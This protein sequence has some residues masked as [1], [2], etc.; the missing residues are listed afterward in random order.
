MYRGAPP[1]GM[2]DAEYRCKMDRAQCPVQM[3]WPDMKDAPGTGTG[4]AK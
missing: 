1:P 3:R 2:T 4:D